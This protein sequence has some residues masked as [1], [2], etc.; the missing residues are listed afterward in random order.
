MKRILSI[1]VVCVIVLINIQVKANSINRI[2]MDIYLD[3]KGNALIKEKWDANLNQGTEGYRAF[4]NLENKTITDF[5]VTD[6]TGNT[7]ETLDHWNTSLSFDEKKYKAGINNTSNGL[8]LC[9][10]ISNYG[11]RQ[12]TL[13]YKI[14]NL[15]TQ[16]TDKQG[17]Y[18]NFL[19][20]NQKV[21]YASI[22]IHSHFPISIDNTRIWSFGNNGTINFQ[23]DKIVM[24]TGGLLQ[25][26]QYIVIMARFNEN[27]FD[28][29]NNSN[30]SFDDIYNEAF[31]SVNDEE[32][33]T[34]NS[35]NKNVFYDSISKYWIPFLLF[36]PLLSIYL[37]GKY[38]SLLKAIIVVLIIVI[39]Y[40]LIVKRRNNKVN[41]YSWL[42][43]ISFFVIL[44]DYYAYYVYIDSKN[45]SNID[46]W[47]EENIGYLILFNLF[48]IIKLVVIS[49]I[50]SHKKSKSLRY[51]YGIRSKYSVDKSIYF[52]EDNKKLPKDKKLNYW[53]EIPCNNDL[54]YAYWIGYEYEICK[55][56]TLFKGLI[57]AYFL[58]WIDNG[59][60]SIVYKEENDD[61]RE[62]CLDFSKEVTMSNDSEKELY[63]IIKSAAN[64]NNLLESKEFKE[65]CKNNYEKI[66]K[67]NDNIQTIVLE[68]L[69]NSGVAKKTVSLKKTI[70]GKVNDEVYEIDVKVRDD[71]IK[72]S[73]LRKYLN[74]FTLI[75]ER[76]PIEVHLW[77]EYLIF[78]EL[79]GIAD[80]VRN[81]FKEL[82]PDL[83]IQNSI[84][85]SEIFDNVA[86]VFIDD[87]YNGIIDGYYIAHPSY[88]SYDSY[89]GSDSS[90][91][92][93]GS[94]FSSGGSSSG[95][96]SGG[97]FR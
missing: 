17:I 4:S 58:K 31:S 80:K 13:Q 81:K 59:N 93:G 5:T 39:S 55:S 65:W 70:F 30:K 3:N 89:G 60:I 49:Y 83:S 75:D 54:S 71:A 86:T 14:N 63:D 66:F 84:F 52:G 38:A 37:I 57:G 19:N 88:S 6:D 85:S 12:Y 77:N 27:Y 42:I 25:S 21:G 15:V 8:E 28:T 29:S 87:C 46:M 95:G 7:Y 97:G 48:P 16:F 50:F 82:Y 61:Q 53:R 79:L 2:D 24:E 76:E 35:K 1:I 9:W 11:N 68:K 36:Q 78:A 33:H 40:L 22:V 73:G 20:L 45:T 32:K 74:D 34:D 47:S 90:S 44:I 18:F 96:S 43:G 26:N 41:L 72:L 67:W 91:G 92:G 10:G 23:D 62:Y 56:G 51:T 94:S 69:C 64:D